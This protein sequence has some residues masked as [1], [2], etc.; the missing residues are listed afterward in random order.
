M[1]AVQRAYPALRIGLIEAY[2]FSSASAIERML[3]LMKARGV[4]PAFLHMDVDWHSLAAGAFERDTTRLQSVCA[5]QA[6]PF[7]IIIVGYNGDS[8]AL[9]AADASSLA[10]L[11]ADTFETWEAMPQHIIFQ[12]WVVS[13]TGESIT[14]SNLPEARGYTHTSLVFNLTRQLRGTVGGPIGTAVP[15]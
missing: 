12:S 10:N 2:P 13:S 8:D 9:Y 11:I 1:T 7:G 3:Q 6:I 5:S 4:A 15:R 14:P